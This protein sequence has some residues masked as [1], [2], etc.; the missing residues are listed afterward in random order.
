MSNAKQ[1]ITE[2]PEKASMSLGCNAADGTEDFSAR[3]HSQKTQPNERVSDKTRGGKVFVFTGYYIVKT[4][5]GM[6]KLRTDTTHEEISE[7]R[8]FAKQESRPVL[9]DP[10]RLRKRGQ[11]NIPF[12]HVR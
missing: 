3:Q 12:F 5:N 11:Y 1:M 6:L 2:I 9:D 4:G 10:I 8:K 7:G